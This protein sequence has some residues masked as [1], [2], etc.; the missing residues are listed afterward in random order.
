[1]DNMVNLF[2]E[3]GINIVK[4]D[5]NFKNI[6]MIFEELSHCWNNLSSEQ[7]SYFANQFI[8]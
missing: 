3:I 7:K 8:N 4:E 1:M 6:N 2:K 5:G